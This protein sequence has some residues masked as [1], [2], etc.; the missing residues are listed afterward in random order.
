MSSTSL[1]RIIEEVKTLTLEE[2]RKVKD[3]I[4]SLLESVVENP[5][6]LPLEDLLEQRLLERGIISQIPKRLPD[7]E[8]YRDFKPVEVK[9]KPV[10][11]TIIEERG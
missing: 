10:S 6:G 3:L 1:E 5:E 8:K 11:E 2:Q 4:D 9:G 7:P